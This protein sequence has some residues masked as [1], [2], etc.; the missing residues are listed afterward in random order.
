MQYIVKTIVGDDRCSNRV[1]LY[2][3]RKITSYRTISHH[4]DILRHL[5]YLY[6]DL[7]VEKLKNRK[8]IYRLALANLKIIEKFNDHL[9]FVICIVCIRLY[10]K[11][12][13]DHMSET[14][15]TH[16]E[17]LCFNNVKH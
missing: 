4:N 14:L 17:Y 6:N 1:D 3:N 8:W 13:K 15:R 7:V 9:R 10:D 16:E 2:L 12:M 5:K 11:A